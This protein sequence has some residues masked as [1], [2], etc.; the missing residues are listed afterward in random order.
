MRTDINGGDIV[1]SGASMSMSGE[2]QSTLKK[3]RAKERSRLIKGKARA[4]DDDS[5]LTLQNI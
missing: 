3:A 1:C 5:D 4:G 2:T